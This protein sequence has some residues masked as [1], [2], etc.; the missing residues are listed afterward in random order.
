MN[1]PPNHIA[2]APPQR[3]GSTQQDVQKQ[4]ATLRTHLLQ[5]QSEDPRCVFVVRRINKVGFRSKAVLEKHYMR[6][7]E[8]RKVL[9]AHSKVRAPPSCSVK[10]RPGNFGLV[11]MRT[12]E[13]VNQILA[14]GSEQIVGGI[15]IQVQPFEQLSMDKAMED[16]EDEP[17]RTSQK[18][19]SHP[20]TAQSGFNVDEGDEWN[21]KN[22][23]SDGSAENTFETDR[24]HARCSSARCSNSNRSHDPAC[25]SSDQ[26]STT[27]T[28]IVRRQGHAGSWKSAL[29]HDVGQVGSMRDCQRDGSSDFQQLGEWGKHCMTSADGIANPSSVVCSNLSLVLNELSL[30]TNGSAQTSHL[31]REQSIQAAA[32]AQWAQHNLKQLEEDCYRKITELSIGYLQASKISSMDRL[33]GSDENSPGGASS[34]PPTSS[35]GSVVAGECQV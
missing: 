1:H 5:L 14:L 34:G 15:E 23:S 30:F 12:P 13:A 20:F 27:A 2:E 28:S 33:E 22:W 17:E 16:E 9:V 11:V 8:V 7:G 35:A 24:R 32:L 21:A 4:R 6:Y 25:S 18:T 19:E 3:V 10:T 29:P 31:D 26:G